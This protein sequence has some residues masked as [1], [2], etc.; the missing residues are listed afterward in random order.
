MVEEVLGLSAYFR[1]F[2]AEGL[3]NK[4][5]DLRAHQLDLV[6]STQSLRTAYLYLSF[7][8]LAAGAMAARLG[9][10]LLG[11]T[12]ANK[13]AFRSFD[14]QV[15]ITTS[16][17][18]ANEDQTAD[19]RKGFLELGKTT[20][21]TSVQAT[22]V[23][24]IFAL[25]GRKFEDE[26]EVVKVVGATLELAT[27]GMISHTEASRFS[28]DV[29]N[30]FRIAQDELGGVV[31]LVA[32]AITNSNLTMQELATSMS[33][34][35]SASYAF[36]IS[37]ADTT[38]YMMASADAG[39]RGGRA[40]RYWREGITRIA[41]SLGASDKV[42]RKAS[43]ATKLLNA[44]NEEAA[45]GIFNLEGDFNGL[46]NMVKV[47]ND[48]YG[49]LDDQTKGVMLAA[50]FGARN[51]A[52]WNAVMEKSEEEL[53]VMTD[54][55]S[56]AQVAWAI[57]ENTMLDGRDALVDL[58][59]Q[60]ANSNRGMIILDD[61]FDAFSDTQKEWIRD[62]IKSIDTEKRMEEAVD[63]V[64]M[65]HAM[66]QMRLEDLHGTIIL[67]ESSM[68]K[69]RVM[70]GT[71]LA[72]P[73]KAWYKGLK[74]IV[75]ALAEV[76]P[77]LLGFFSIIV[78]I[79]GTLSSFGG[80]IAMTIGGV[81][82][83][84]AAL[85]ILVQQGQTATS[86]TRIMADGFRLLSSTVKLSAVTVMQHSKALM[87]HTASAL[88]PMIIAMMLLSGGTEEGNEW[89]TTLGLTLLFVLTPAIQAATFALHAH[90]ASQ[91]WNK[92]VAIGAIVVTK[93]QTAAFVIL[94]ASVL[95]VGAAFLWA[96]GPAFIFMGITVPIWAVLLGIAAVV[97]IIVALFLKLTGRT[98]KLG[99]VFEKVFI[100]RHS[101]AFWEVLKLSAKYSAMNV[102]NFE[103]WAKVSSRIAVP[104]V[105][106]VENLAGKFRTMKIGM[107]EAAGKGE[108]GRS[109]QV[110]M[111]SGARINLTKES[112]PGFKSIVDEAVDATLHKLERML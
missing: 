60:Y 38:A 15:T 20:E 2:G 50:I 31:N 21:W 85:A 18:K 109:A 78:L 51:W 52:S 67:Y 82:M 26:I 14:H 71:P 72:R 23:G 30:Q 19:L 104:E 58:M 111:F 36:G 97:A 46:V 98:E 66:A 49:D 24:R 34:A 80:M 92:I 53:Q 27:V 63:D 96:A 6:S 43:E 74:L 1:S 44:A 95:G 81:F 101:P 32:T 100:K 25:A 35:G 65:S 47:L 11:M 55:L 102:K 87:F 4:I 37:L 70:M 5:I 112:L 105:A 28:I 13:E 45:E 90:T 108:V 62:T 48:A 107:A 16:I 22:E 84:I 33:Y 75:D 64:T 7:G 57:E 3:K 54:S 59:E 103:R 41:R 40:G 9:N 61:T 77:R 39:I 12:T 76:D 69:L 29:T 86:M 73:Y 79:I 17:M 56:A 83:L 8:L 68:D 88:G 110:S 91:I 10:M 89:M 93:L 99:K 42:T 94:A 106:G